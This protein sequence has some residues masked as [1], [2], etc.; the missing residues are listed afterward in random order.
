MSQN[1]SH[2][3]LI[4]QHHEAAPPLQ[5]EGYLPY[6]LTVLASEIS[7]AFAQL[8]GDM[9][10]LA[11]P[12]WRVVATLGQFGTM[13]AKEICQHSRMHK[14]TVSRAVA[15][16][17]KRKL[18]ALRT[19]REDMREVFLMLSEEGQ[20]LY[21]KLV[22]IAL[23]FE[24]DLCRELSNEDKMIFQKVIRQFSARLEHFQAK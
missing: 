16:L 2:R 9:F 24:E 23:G 19:N 6:Q 4:E 20:K 7:Q 3:V 5:L 17:E 12:E 22:P 15:A 1:S 13:T 14:T 10:V 18:L 21:F 8:H 11:I